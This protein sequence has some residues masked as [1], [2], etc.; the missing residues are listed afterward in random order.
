VAGRRLQG[1]IEQLQERGLADAIVANNGN[2]RLHIQ[3]DFQV[4]K[5]YI[6]RGGV[7]EGSIYV[8]RARP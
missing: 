3:A 4:L 6:G 2:A 5:E 7:A 8:C 1:A